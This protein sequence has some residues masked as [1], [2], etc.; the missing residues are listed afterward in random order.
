MTM[1]DKTNFILRFILFAATHSFFATGF[2]K[3][4]FHGTEWR[5]YRICYNIGSLAMF[6]WVMSA[7]RHSE[8]LY[9]V[10][11]VWSLVMYLLQLIVM[12]I[13]ATCLKQTGAGEFFGLTRQRSSAFVSSGWYSLVRHPLYLFSIM[14]MILNPVMT[15][16][17]LMLTIMS[18]IYFVVGSLIEERRLA[19][20]FGD[21]YRNYQKHVPFF[22]PNIANIIALH[23]K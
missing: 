6:G 18:I 2:A 12:V 11:G 5:G 1:S 8:V 3:E 23:N 4:T 20:E 7:Y 19:E 16:Q 14:F 15:S 13:L 9:F 21:A 10:P 17:W 22:I